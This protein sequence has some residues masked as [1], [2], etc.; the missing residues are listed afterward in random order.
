MIRNE[1]FIAH[2]IGCLFSVK[3]KTTLESGCAVKVPFYNLYLL[4]RHTHTHILWV[5]DNTCSLWA[6]L[7]HACCF[8]TKSV[9][10]IT[11]ITHHNASCCLT[12]ESVCWRFISC[13]IELADCKAAEW[14]S[15]ET[16]CVRA[17]FRVELRDIENFS[18]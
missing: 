16:V 18:L 17:L 11:I 8:L 2:F 14:L 1:L 15:P 7:S 9:I 5:I 13:K 4:P 12:F 3:L 10:N 6:F